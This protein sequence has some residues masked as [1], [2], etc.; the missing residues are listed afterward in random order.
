M[1]HSV[2]HVQW[3]I[4][5]FL[6]CYPTDGFNESSGW[7]S[8]KAA[9]AEFFSTESNF[10]N[11][12]KKNSWIEWAAAAAALFLLPFES[13]KKAELR[14]SESNQI[15]TA[16][17]TNR[18]TDWL[19]DRHILFMTYFDAQRNSDTHDFKLNKILLSINRRYGSVNSWFTFCPRWDLR[20]TI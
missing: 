9:A 2:T 1:P 10:E 20:L 15:K 8:C 13:Y 18:Q 5:D 4:P 14:N 16:W 7:P 17:P 12:E 3:S 11:E 6:D 19:T